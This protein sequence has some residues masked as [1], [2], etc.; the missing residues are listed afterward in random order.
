MGWFHEA[1]R[2]A[3][4]SFNCDRIV[5]LKPWMSREA[6][7]NLAVKCGTCETPSISYV[8]SPIQRRQHMAH[9]A[10]TPHTHRNTHEFL[11]LQ[12]YHGSQKIW[13]CAE[14]R[15]SFWLEISA[16]FCQGNRYNRKRSIPFELL[17]REQKNSTVRLSSLYQC[18][19]F[20]WGWLQV[21]VSSFQH[22][23]L[24]FWR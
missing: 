14:D 11:E 9:E 1:F 17:K 21:R 10:L 22:F 2:Q 5:V 3:G 23:L 8:F 16:S 19:F 6:R 24:R 20:S 12:V 7:V 4:G 15:E 13:A 18:S